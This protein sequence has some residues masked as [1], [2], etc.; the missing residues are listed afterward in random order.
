M[1]QIDYFNKVLMFLNELNI[2]LS[3]DANLYQKFIDFLYKNCP[4]NKCIFFAENGY[5]QWKNFKNQKL[6]LGFIYVN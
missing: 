3:N 2:S 5:L 6:T 1:P 4:T